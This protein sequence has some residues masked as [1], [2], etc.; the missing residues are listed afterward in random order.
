MAAAAAP[1]GQSVVQN[2]AA[3]ATQNAGLSL[4]LFDLEPAV[5]DANTLLSLKMLKDVDEATYGKLAK[6]TTRFLSAGLALVRNDPFMR[7]KLGGDNITTAMR[8]APILKQRVEEQHIQMRIDGVAKQLMK[9]SGLGP[10]LLPL[11]GASIKKV[12]AVSRNGR[13]FFRPRNGRCWINP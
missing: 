10:E 7:I 12:F 13:D 11:T 2:Q 1:A 3:N 5:P 8:L 9:T 4:N 6:E